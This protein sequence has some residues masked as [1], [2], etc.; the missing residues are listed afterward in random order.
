MVS[1]PSVGNSGVRCSEWLLF[2][3]DG[4]FLGGLTAA[5]LDSPMV[6]IDFSG[7]KKLKLYEIT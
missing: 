5:F 3:W 6:S 7:K 4:F 1:L 2:S